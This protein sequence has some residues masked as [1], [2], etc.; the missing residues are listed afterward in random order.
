MRSRVFALAYALT[1]CARFGYE[2]LALDDATEGSLVRGA[3]GRQVVGEGGSEVVGGGGDEAGSTQGGQGASGTGEA[4][5]GGIGEGGAGGIGTPASGG[6]GAGDAGGSA[7]G[8]SATGGSATGGSATGGTSGGISCADGLQNGDEAGVDCGGAGCAACTCT[9]GVAERIVIPN[10][11]GN[12][13]WGPTLSSD[14]LTMYV[15]F[16]VPGENEQIGVS[17]R[18]DRGNTFGSV[19]PLPAPVN[20]AVEGTPHLSIDGRSLYFYST[21]GAGDHNL[22]VATRP[23][24][25]SAFSAVSQLS[26]INST[27]IDQLPWLSADELIIY[28]ASNRGG[29]MDVYSA[30]RGARTDAFG[31]AA[32]VTE[33]NSTASD[34]RVTLTQDELVAIL[35]TD[36]PGAAGGWDLYQFVRADRDDPFSAPTALDVLNTGNMEADPALSPDGQELFFVSTRGGLAEIWRSQRSCL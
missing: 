31:F 12:E 25:A 2:P 32:P 18:P 4:G 1:A 23:D 24:A 14:G 15:G 17:T 8:G 36:R 33:L 5:A 11:G 26:S 9:F 20:Q 29:S 21:R 19:A 7:T 34:N 10:N 3:D 6:T 13:L 30:T 22:Y 35:A 27:A 28:F 16:V